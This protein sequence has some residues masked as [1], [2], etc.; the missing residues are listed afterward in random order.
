MNVT[1]KY[2]SYNTEPLFRTNAVNQHVFV[3]V[4]TRNHVHGVDDV[5]QEAAATDAVDRH[6]GDIAA[7]ATAPD[8]NRNR[9]VSS[10][11]FEATPLR[12]LQ[13]DDDV[14]RQTSMAV[15]G[16]TDNAAR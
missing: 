4:A 15:D 16:N 11:S 2:I 3:V 1:V 12:W 8:A 10:P 6:H 13:Q 9:L 5:A 14:S 7:L